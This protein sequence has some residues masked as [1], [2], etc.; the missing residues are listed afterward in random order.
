M[1]APG[2]LRVLRLRGPSSTHSW[3]CQRIW[4]CQN[5]KNAICIAHFAVHRDFRVATRH[6]HIKRKSGMD[7]LVS[8]EG[9]ESAL[10][11]SFNN[12]KGSGWRSKAL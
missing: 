6:A 4:F 1:R 8:A 12:L 5:L 11:C 3:F 10:E 9:I 7:N 2:Q